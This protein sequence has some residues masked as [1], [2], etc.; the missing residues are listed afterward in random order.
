LRAVALLG[1]GQARIKE[2][3]GVGGG[4]KGEAEG[5]LMEQLPWLQLGRGKQKIAYRGLRSR[6]YCCWRTQE[7]VK[8]AAA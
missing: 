4:G 2:K 1:I 3:A 5:L 6:R 7:G 8:A